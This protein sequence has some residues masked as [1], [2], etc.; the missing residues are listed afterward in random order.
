MGTPQQLID[1]PPLVYVSYE[2]LLIAL[3]ATSCQYITRQLPPGLTLY[4]NAEG[5]HDIT[6]VAPLTRGLYE[7][8][9]T[10]TGCQTCLNEAGGQQP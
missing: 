5:L 2:T 7:V 9:Q 6:A 1:A 3:N 8:H 4:R 10:V